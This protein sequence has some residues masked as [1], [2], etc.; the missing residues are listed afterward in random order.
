MITVKKDAI[1]VKTSEGMQS[2]G[3]L[4]NVGTFWDVLKL[5]GR[6]L[7]RMFE[8]V[9]FPDGTNLAIDIPNFGLSNADQGLN[10]CFAEATGIK[11]IKLKCDDNGLSRNFSQAFISCKSVETIDLSEFPVRSSNAM[12]LFYY[13]ESLGEILGELDLTGSSVS[14]LVAGCK[15]LKEIRFKNKCIGNS[16]AFDHCPLLSDTSIQSIIN[17][18]A[19]L[20]G[21]TAQTVTFNATVKAKLTEA[22][23]ASIT[24]KNWTLA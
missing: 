10:R 22:Q 4:C 1:K 16:V 7:T 17:G 12:Q 14:Y 20:T 15:N 18:L 24:S 6:N 23:I 9:A 13:C 5:Y 8:K 19:D 2:V 11:S 21:Q 3:V